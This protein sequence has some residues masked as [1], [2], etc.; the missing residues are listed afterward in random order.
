MAAARCVNQLRCNPDAVADL[1]MGSFE[2]VPNAKLLGFVSRRGL[3]PR[4]RNWN[5]GLP[6][7]T[8]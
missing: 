8:I 5:C 4:R 2:N 6:R 7:K 3:N 1:A